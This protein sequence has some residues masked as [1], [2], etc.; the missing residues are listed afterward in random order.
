MMNRRIKPLLLLGAAAGVAVFGAV[1]S[2]AAQTSPVTQSGP[3]PNAP[4]TAPPPRLSPA[5]IDAPPVSSRNISDAAETHVVTVVRDGK[6]YHVTVHPQRF[7][8]EMPDGTVRERIQLNPDELTAQLPPLP[9]DQLPSV[10]GG[11]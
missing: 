8:E 10:P 4:L 9:K 11:K 2:A 1:V 5:E 7:L 6:T 3:G